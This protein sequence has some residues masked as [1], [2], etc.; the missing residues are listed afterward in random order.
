MPSIHE[1]LHGGC[2][3][4]LMVASLL[5]SNF[6]LD[7]TN[8]NWIKQVVLLADVSY[9]IQ[10]QVELASVLWMQMTVLCINPVFS[11]YLLNTMCVLM[12]VPEP[13]LLFQQLLLTTPTVTS[14]F[15]LL[16]LQVTCLMSQII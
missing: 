12:P 8:N 10:L 1:D 4:L 13:P 11:L 7:I 5:L 16:Q 6:V 2:R 3:K 15:P 9:I 14:Y